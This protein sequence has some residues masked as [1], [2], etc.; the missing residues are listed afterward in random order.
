MVG[1][2]CEE[3]SLFILARNSLENLDEKE[4]FSGAKG[5]KKK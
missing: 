5:L 1:S 2:D 4:M 3:K